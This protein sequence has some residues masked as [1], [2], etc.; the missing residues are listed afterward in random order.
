MFTI[1]QRCF[2]GQSYCSGKCRQLGRQKIVR[3]AGLKYSQTQA[4]RESHRKRQRKYRTRTPEEKTE[5]H[6]SISQSSVRVDMSETKQK[7]AEFIAGSHCRICSA[8][9][10]VVLGGL[11]E[12]QLA[13]SR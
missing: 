10:L 13:W 1:C 7:I 5:T 9:C 8:E 3:S 12:Y 11:R 6:P 2:R 4:G